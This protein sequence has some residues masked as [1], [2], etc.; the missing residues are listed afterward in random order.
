MLLCMIILLHLLTAYF[1]TIDFCIPCIFYNQPPNKPLCR[2]TLSL[3]ILQC[4]LIYFLIC[5]LDV[6]SQNTC[7]HAYVHRHTLL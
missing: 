1:R 3:I 5:F 7:V 4:E 6:R 2:A